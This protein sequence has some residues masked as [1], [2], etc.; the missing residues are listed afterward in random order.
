MILQV[1]LHI[2]LA[3]PFYFLC[4]RPFHNKSLVGEATASNTPG[5]PVLVAQPIRPS[6]SEATL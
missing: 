5:A 6:M 3:I 1:G 2:L 4:E